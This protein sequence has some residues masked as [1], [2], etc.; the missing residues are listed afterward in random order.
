MHSASHRRSKR[1]FLPA[2]TLAVALAAVIPLPLPAA[3]FA[4]ANVPASGT[5]SHALARAEDRAQHTIMIG[6]I[7]L[8]RHRHLAVGGTMGC[9][10][11]AGL[12][13]GAG[14]ALG[15][16]TGGVGLAAV[17]VAS[18]IGCSLAGFAGASLGAPLDNYQM[19]LSD[20]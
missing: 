7:L 20:L 4:G 1:F 18:A 9:G 12:G 16:V 15:L 2:G 19:D 8:E 14:V 3:S 11:G 6:G 13:A 10:I 17:P 5:I